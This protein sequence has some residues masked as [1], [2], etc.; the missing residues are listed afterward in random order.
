MERKD[1]LNYW[2]DHG[3]ILL[4][5]LALGGEQSGIEI[6]RA[7][8]RRKTQFEK[9][10]YAPTVFKTLGLLCDLKLV[11]VRMNSEESQEQTKSKFH[12]RLTELGAKA[13]YAKGLIS[14]EI[15][16][17]RIE[18]REVNPYDFDEEIET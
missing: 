6:S 1:R 2:P 7:T 9:G 3:D 18:E 15:M 13:A 11:E 12:F 8:Y 14:D 5:Q 17:A 10:L 16:A 4:E